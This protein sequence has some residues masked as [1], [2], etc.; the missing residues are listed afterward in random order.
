MK[1]TAGVAA[2]K[3]QLEHRRACFD[4]LRRAHG[5]FPPPLHQGARPLE[6]DLQIHLSGTTLVQRTDN[7]AGMRR[8]NRG[9]K[10]LNC[11]H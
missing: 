11:T 7:T 5:I 4:G 1:C 3:M 8:S 10:F 2:P 6:L 9:L